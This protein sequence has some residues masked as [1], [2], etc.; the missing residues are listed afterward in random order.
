MYSELNVCKQLAGIKKDTSVDKRIKCK[1]ER[2]NDD[3]MKYPCWYPNISIKISN[4]ARS[5]RR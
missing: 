4:V 1:T 3:A 2:G 5:Y